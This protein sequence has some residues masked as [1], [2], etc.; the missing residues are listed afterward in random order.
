[1]D[2]REA[3]ERAAELGMLA[4]QDYAQ[5]CANLNAAREQ[6]F[7]IPPEF[8]RGLVHARISDI[9]ATFDAHDPGIYR[10]ADSGEPHDLYR[11]GV[12]C[13]KP[14]ESPFFGTREEW[15]RHLADKLADALAGE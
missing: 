1:M 7:P 8:V 11:C 10:A 6:V 2:T 15:E 5:A 14:P 13:A 4:G 12:G 3:I 9:V